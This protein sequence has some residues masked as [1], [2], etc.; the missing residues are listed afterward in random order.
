MNE[1][2]IKKTGVKP[3]LR[4]LHSVATVFSVTPQNHA[5]EDVAGSINLLARLGV[6]ALVAFGTGADDKDPD[7]VVVQVASPNS[8]GLPAKDYYKDDSVLKSYEA[9]IAEVL[10]AVHPVPKH[11][12]SNADSSWMQFDQI[13]VYAHEVVEL[14]KKLAAA[15]P[16]A[17]DRDDV[18]VSCFL[19]R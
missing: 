1:D 5:T 14:E 8:I 13:K 3:L 2:A 9:T 12:S 6:S 16:D 4:L 7:E 11:G 17:E 18:D 10:E 19:A 15:S